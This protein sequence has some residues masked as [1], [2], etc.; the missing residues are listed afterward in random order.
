MTFIKQDVQ[1]QKNAARSLS[2]A[3]REAI[4]SSTKDGLQNAY[5]VEVL[6][7]VLVTEQSVGE[8]ADAFARMR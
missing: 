6:E 2:I 3:I 1:S 5:V 8:T 4:I 7:S